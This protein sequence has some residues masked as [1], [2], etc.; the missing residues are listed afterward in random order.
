MRRMHPK[1]RAMQSKMK[2]CAV[3]WKRS[4]KK[5]KYTAFMSKCLKGG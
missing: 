3:K 4:P 1:V 2:G 5:G